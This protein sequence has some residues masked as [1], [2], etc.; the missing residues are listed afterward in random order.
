MQFCR[1]Q[2]LRYRRNAIEKS[3]N[4]VFGARVLF[5]SFLLERARSTREYVTKITLVPT[6][7]PSYEASLAKDHR[8][9]ERCTLRSPVRSR[10][11]TTEQRVNEKA[12]RGK[13]DKGK[14]YVNSRGKKDALASARL[15]AQK[16]RKQFMCGWKPS[17]FTIFTLPC[18]NICPLTHIQTHI[19]ALSS[20]YLSILL[21]HFTA[22]S[23][24][25][26]VCPNK[27]LE[28]Q[29]FMWS[30]T[31]WKSRVIAQHSSKLPRAKIPFP[32][33]ISP[34]PPPFFSSFFLSCSLPEAAQPFGQH[35]C[36]SQII[37]NR[38]A[39]I[40]GKHHHVLSSV[41]R[42]RRASRIQRCSTGGTETA[43]AQILITGHRL[44]T[45]WKKR[46]KRN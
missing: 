25:H 45:T 10:T 5:F 38:A 16:S 28:K 33:R 35:G 40:T 22:S 11:K 14:A 4:R 23:P 17:S 30:T 42:S 44:T 19:R 41:R 34:P 26:C 46:K 12:T 3:R 18:R 36:A 31:D 21:I 32:R 2:F 39:T 29:S 27:I 43:G 15:H 8:I 20:F 37:S 24:S 9:K 1:F 6:P 7:L 13:R